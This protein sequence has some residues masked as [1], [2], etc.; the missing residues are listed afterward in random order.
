MGM[1]KGQVNMSAYIQKKT[2]STDVYNAQ[3]HNTQTSK[4]ISCV[5]VQ[6]MS[7]YMCCVARSPE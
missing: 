2:Y 6:L 7:L 5:K 1:K 3:H 4:K